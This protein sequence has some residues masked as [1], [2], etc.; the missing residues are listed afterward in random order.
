MDVTTKMQAIRTE[1]NIVSQGAL[2]NN[3]LA[4]SREVIV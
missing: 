2:Q 4:I 3:E 1:H